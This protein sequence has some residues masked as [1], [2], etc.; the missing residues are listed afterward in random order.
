MS[1]RKDMEKATKEIIKEVH[2][3]DAEI[4]AFIKDQFDKML[5]HCEKTE[6]T[7][8]IATMEVLEGMEEGLKAE[9]RKIKE[10]FRKVASEIFNRIPESGK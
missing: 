2:T 3:E 5:E 6:T 7:A 10:S 4:E 8:K 1:L 9:S